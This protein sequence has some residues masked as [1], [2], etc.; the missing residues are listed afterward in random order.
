MQNKK[1]YILLSDTGTWLS[2]CIRFYTRHSLN[3]ASISFD[4]HLSEV[5]GFGRLNPRNP[6]LGGF[7]KEEVF[8]N[9]VRD[10]NRFTNCVIFS[11]AVQ[12][13]VYERIRRRIEYFKCNSNRYRYNFLGLFGVMLDIPLRR[14]QAYFC[15]EFVSWLLHDHGMPLANKHPSL[16]TPADILA[17][18]KLQ[19]V[20]AGDL[21]RYHA[22]ANYKL[23][24]TDAAAFI[25]QLDYASASPASNLLYTS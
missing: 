1:L 12:P 16:M 5:Y 15:T 18:D 2:K 10:E 3:H 6:F 20:Y 8:G 19:L 22:S 14:K 7:T 13:E 21:R 11:F 9:L 17:C 25:E 4:E 24:N 23:N